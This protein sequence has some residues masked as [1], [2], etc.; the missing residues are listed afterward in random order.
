MKPVNQ[1]AREPESKRP[2]SIKGKR[3]ASAAVGAIG[4]QSTN[5]KITE[6]DNY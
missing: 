6:L 4:R 1:T 5:G 2:Q 3:Q